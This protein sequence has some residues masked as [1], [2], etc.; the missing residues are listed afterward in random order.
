MDYKT[1]LKTSPLEF[2]KTL[3]ESFISNTV[4]YANDHV[5]MRKNEI[6]SANINDLE[7]KISR[8]EKWLAYIEFQQHTLN[9]LEGCK[10]DNLIP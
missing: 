10:I 5:A 1:W 2:K 9:E 8:I 6:S 4:A 3:I 7:E